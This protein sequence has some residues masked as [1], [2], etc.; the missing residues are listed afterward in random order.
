V[1]TV[2][3]DAGALIALDRDHRQ[4]IALLA[5]AAEIGARVTV[6]ATALAQAMRAP[7]RQARLSRLVRQPT[8]DVVPLSTADAISV[9][10]LLSVTR[11]SDITDA[12]VA[13]CAR[14][15]RGP[16]VTSD[17]DDLARLDPDAR[18]VRV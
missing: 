4:M 9:G 8:T 6:P 14:R 15:A 1:T 2:T 17:P 5:H 18:L 11:T 13:L 3:L 7:A 10:V 16:I 12:H